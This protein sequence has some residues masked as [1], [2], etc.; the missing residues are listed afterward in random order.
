M[1]TGELS[2][3]VQACFAFVSLSIFFSDPCEVAHAQAFYSP[4]SSSYNES[5]GPTDGLGAGQ[6]LCCRAQ[7]LGVA[8]DDFNGVGMLGL[9]ACHPALGQWHDMV[10]L[11]H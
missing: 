2:C 5:R 8:N 3:I 1:S 7:Q 11:R 6:T 10:S 4:R 9:V